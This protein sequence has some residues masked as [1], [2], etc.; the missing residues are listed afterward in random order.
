M[1]LKTDNLL[2][3]IVLFLVG[4]VALVK[5]SGWFIDSSVYIA[6]NR[7]FLNYVFL[8]GLMISGFIAFLSASP[9]IMIKSFGLAEDR[10]GLLFSLVAVFFMLGTF[11]SG[12]LVIRFGQNRLIAWG[13]CIALAGG[14][15]MVSLALLDIRTPAAVF[16]PMAVYAIGL[17]LVLPQAN[18]SALQPFPRM[19]G[20]ASS[21]Q[22]FIQ[23]VMAAAVSFSLTAA[24]NETAL[25]MA[26]VIAAVG[27]INFLIYFIAIT[28]QAGK[29]N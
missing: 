5:G 1:D 29:R 26:G 19:A 7:V 18:A 13:S 25:A 28:P 6:R 27:L 21:V 20:M 22:G 3:N 2:V 24:T 14:V 17:S 9:T 12:R 23:S 4:L 10:F 16:A 11:T 8:G 15:I